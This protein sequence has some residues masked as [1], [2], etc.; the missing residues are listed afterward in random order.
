MKHPYLDFENTV[1]WKE[2]QSELEEL[3]ENQDIQL[4]TANQYVVGSICRRLRDA[5]LLREQIALR[6]VVSD[7]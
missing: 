6:K 4:T 5:G 2:L 1:V 3:I 7:E